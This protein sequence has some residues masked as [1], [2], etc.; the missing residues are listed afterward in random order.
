MIEQWRHITGEILWNPQA[1]E[2][3][4]MEIIETYM[5]DAVFQGADRDVV[6][7]I[8]HTTGDPEIIKTICI[9]REATRVG[10]QS[11]RSG[12]NII[13]DVTMLKAGINLNKVRE[14]GGEIICKISDPDTV[15]AAKA[16]KITRSAASMRLLGEQLDGAVVAIGNAPT[17]L[18]EVL[19]L[20][21]K[22]LARPA[23]IIGTPVG[24]VGAMESK[25]VLLAMEELP[26]IVIRG[27]RGG[28]T[29]AVSA[30]NALLY[31]QGVV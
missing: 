5:Q 27:T 13:T 11:L 31:F 3:K 6:K 16:W 28:S 1:I 21:S 14:F 26:S 10:I 24:F 25:E 12:C 22:G 23:L 9:H 2:Q 29:I 19:D 20:Y 4:S 30:V 8:V 18:Y 7:R 15:Q 17:A